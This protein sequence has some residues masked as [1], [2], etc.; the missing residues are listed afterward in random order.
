[1]STNTEAELHST[2]S[3]DPLP[4]FTK[5]YRVFVWATMYLEDK[6]DVIAALRHHY[7]DVCS[8]GD[9][10]IHELI[11]FLESSDTSPTAVTALYGSK[12]TIKH[13]WITCWN[14]MCNTLEDWLDKGMLDPDIWWAN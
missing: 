10:C 3:I 11:G 4:A 1:M 7:G 12:D 2:P 14:H 6:N 9:L 13:Y 5:T 8:E